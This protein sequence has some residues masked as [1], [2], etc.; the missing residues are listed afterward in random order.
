MNLQHGRIP[1]TNQRENYS[2]DFPGYSAAYGIALDIPA[3][4]DIRWQHVEVDPR[5]SVEKN[6]LHIAEQIK[7]AITRITSI[8]DGN[9][10]IICI[11]TEW[12][13]YRNYHNDLE[14]FDL[15]DH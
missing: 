11:P 14:I 15:H 12:A 10:I 5:L 2:I 6:A 8:L 4:T 1:V 3:T 7:N 9:L 13:G